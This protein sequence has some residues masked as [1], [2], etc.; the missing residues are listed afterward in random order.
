MRHDELKGRGGKRDS[1]L[2]TDLLDLC[3]LC[4]DGVRRGRVI[5]FSAGLCARREDAG[6]EAASYCDRHAALLTE[7]QKSVERFLLQQRKTAREKEAVEVPSLECLMAHFP[8]V[9][10]DA[11]RLDDV[12]IAQLLKRFPASIHCGLEHLRLSIAPREAIDV[13]DEADVYSFDTQPVQRIL[14]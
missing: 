10:A 5:V 3:D 14:E 1:E 6:V 13:M 11:D 8:F 7:R 4:D 9:D 12:L 2:R